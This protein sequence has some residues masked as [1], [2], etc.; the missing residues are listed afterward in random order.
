MLEYCKQS[1]I[2]FE[3]YS[4]LATGK[5]IES[6]SKLLNEIAK[7]HNKSVAQVLIRWGLQH[8]TVVLPR[9][10]QKQHIIDNINVF[11]FELSKEDMQALNGMNKNYRK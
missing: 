5:L 6:E 7:K 8:E 2:V 3:A 9:S 11:D 10:T 4:P 1:K